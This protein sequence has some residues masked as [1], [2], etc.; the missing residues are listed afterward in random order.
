MTKP[1]GALRIHRRFAKSDVFTGLAMPLNLALVK[2]KQAVPVHSHH[3][4][5]L[6]IVRAG[7]GVH[8]TE[9]KEYP[10][11]T[12][13]VFIIH[14]DEPHGYA[15]INGFEVINIYFNPSAL[16]LPF[17]DM[18]SMPGY[19][20]LFS[21]EPR[22][23]RAWGVRNQLRLAL[24]EQALAGKLAEDIGQETVRRAHGSQAL[25]LAHFYELVILLSRCYEKSG[26][27]DSSALFRL[28]SALSHIETNYPEKIVLKELAAIAHMSQSAFQ[29]AF[30]LALDCSPINYIIRYRILKAV[31]I[32]RDPSQKISQAGY[33][34]GFEDSN[35]FSRQFR[36]IMGMSPKA[37]RLKNHT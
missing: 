36:S 11:R 27:V 22:L 29:R 8:I 34:T 17:R 26:T 1:T 37:Y 14:E 31:E 2:L 16:G 6:V 3:F 32:L 20:A 5:E 9:T 24:N 19:R 4:T 30:R 25:A 12:G 13:D 21:L 35:Y 15:D 28:G 33:Q 18:S 10:V 7:R 23:R